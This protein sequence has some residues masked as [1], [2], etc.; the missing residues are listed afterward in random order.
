MKKLILLFTCLAIISISQAQ[1]QDKKWN[2][3]LHGGLTQ[4][5]GDLG[6]DFYKTDMVAYGVG[7]ISLSRYIGSHFDLNLSIMKGTVGFSRYP[8]NFRGEFTSALINFRFNVVAPRY[9][10]RPYI[11]VGAGAMLFDKNI[12]ISSKKVDYIAP[13]FGG[14]ANFRITPTLMLNIQETFMYSS[15]D[16]R[17]GLV[18]NENDMYVLHTVGLTFNF[19][20]KHDADN[21]GVNDRSDK[22]ADTPPGVAV[23]KSG[24]P[25]DKDK[26]GVADYLD[27][28]PDVAGTKEL[29]GCPDADGDGIAD[30]DDRCP[31]VR[32]SLT[33]M[34]CPDAD[35]DGIADLDDICP[36]TK[37]GYNVNAVGCPM[38]N[39]NDGIV[40]EEDRCPDASG[41]ASLTGCPDTDGDG[42]VD[43]DDRCPEI[44]GTLTNQGCPEIPK[45]VEIKITQIASKIFFESNSDVLKVASLEQLNELV[46]ILK[47]YQ[48][49][50][51][52]IDGHTDSQGSDE[53]NQILSQ[54]RTESVKTYLMGK[55]IME[56]RLTTTGFGEK[57]PIADNNSS[58]GRAKNRRVE[59][60]TS[61]KQ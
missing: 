5:N 38:D 55:G 20:K 12:E 52:Q 42:V 31:N 46:K 1:T 60:K 53:F 18:K 27:V 29:K 49:A 16:N 30:K 58:A 26:D 33:L 15:A 25:L 10:V 4:Y 47:E 34:G 9:A 8:N 57:N 13:S 45:E 24:C 41:P 39:D 59:L 51:L 23:D 50:N 3:G 54:K 19:G 7:G 40:N 21:D 44:K 11:F 32:G 35:G 37:A 43:L 6:N 14:G 61:Y 56:S 17:D 36:D 22:C 48:T 2:F 28:C